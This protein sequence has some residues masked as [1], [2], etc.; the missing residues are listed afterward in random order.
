MDTWIY[1]VMRLD[2][3]VRK[4]P[5]IESFYEKETVDLVVYKICFYCVLAKPEE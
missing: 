4:A 3:F 2:G 5:W 1:Y